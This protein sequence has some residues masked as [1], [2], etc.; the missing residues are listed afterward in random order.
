MK[1]KVFFRRSLFTGCLV[2]L[3][4]FGSSLA[5]SESAQDNEFAVVIKARQASF[6]EL[7]DAMKVYRTEL[8][9]DSP[10]NSAM[11]AAAGVVASYADEIVDWFPVGSGPES[12]LDTDALPYIWKNTEKFSRLGA[13]I[14][15]ASAALTAA[16][17][18]ND[19]KAIISQVSATG[20]ACKNCHGSFRAD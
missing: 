13:E 1:R 11:A 6:K 7:G 4:V 15:L 8:R 2:S 3:L 19:T 9:S 12:G 14:V 16:V 5:S 18:S 20:K 17:A 10:D